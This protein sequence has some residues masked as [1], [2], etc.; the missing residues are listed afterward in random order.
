MSLY[1]LA[2]GNLQQAYRLLNCKDLF[3][4]KAIFKVC[5]LLSKNERIGTRAIETFM[6]IKPPVIYPKIRDAMFQQFCGG[7]DLTDLSPYLRS[8]KLAG[9]NP[10]V[11]FGSEYSTKT[12]ELD[13]TKDEL[14]NIIDYMKYYNGHAICKATSIMSSVRLAKVQA[15]ETMGEDETR[16]WARDVSRMEDVCSYAV[17]K[18]VPIYFD[19]ETIDIQSEI[20]RRVME[21]M[22]EYNGIGANGSWDYLHGRE[23][24]VYSTIQFYRKDSLQQL[25]ELVDDCT[26]H[27]YVAGLK[28]VRGAYMHDE[29][30]AGNRDLLHNTKEDT[31]ESYNDGI[32]FCMEHLGKI[33]MLF[34]T[35]N[36]TSVHT[37][38]EHMEEKTIPPRNPFVR[39]GQMYGMRQDI[40]FNLHGV[41]VTQFIPYGPK[42]SLFGYLV[43]RGIEN[44]SALNGSHIEVNKTIRE[45]QRR[46]II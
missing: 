16:E 26:K 43:R 36:E 42:D 28:L 32:R 46:I 19:G 1:S 8:L 39:I 11:S 37:V 29:S 10:L 24:N 34:A 3:R 31:D 22:R 2:S 7:E 25:R 35:H 27:H 20:H 15:N 6:Q 5:D 17:K 38:L 21:M 12:E 40:T 41:C 4:Q 9:I 14:M 45:I 13:Q 23:P 18:R 44:T 33:G 30:I